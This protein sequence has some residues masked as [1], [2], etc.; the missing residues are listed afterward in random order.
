MSVV[1]NSGSLLDLF[2]ELGWTSGVNDL[3]QAVLKSE[4]PAAVIAAYLAA[5]IANPTTLDDSAIAGVT[6]KEGAEITAFLEGQ[7]LVGT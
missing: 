2:A 5:L 1:V 7:G 3:V 6:E 4:I